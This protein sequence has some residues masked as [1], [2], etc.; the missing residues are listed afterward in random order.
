MKKENGIISNF[1]KYM[2][3]KKLL[4]ST[5]ENWMAVPTFN[6]HSCKEKEKGTVNS[7]P[8]KKKHEIKTKKSFT[9]LIEMNG[10]SVKKKE[11]GTVNKK[12]IKKR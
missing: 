6:G 11:K 2:K 9:Y 12:N 3:K 8:K 7:V 5:S 4:S 10:H 1:P